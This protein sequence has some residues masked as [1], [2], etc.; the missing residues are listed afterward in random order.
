MPLGVRVATACVGSC[1]IALVVLSS[2]CGNDTQVPAQTP[3]S[4]SGGFH[5]DANLGCDDASLP[6]RV[7]AHL[8]SG[9]CQGSEPSCHGGTDNPANL[10]FHGDPESNLRQLVNVP[11]NE[12]PDWMRVNP[13]HPEISWMLAKLRNDK[14]AGVEV[15]MPKG[16]DGDP[17]FAALVEEWILSGASTSL[18]ASPEAEAETEAATDASDAGAEAEIDAEIDGDGG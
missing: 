8:A 14:D 1:V 5:L 3:D 16:S 11:A 15:A 12:R 4:G 6:C 9:S 10:Y 18:D 2:S 17:V 13:Y 7:A